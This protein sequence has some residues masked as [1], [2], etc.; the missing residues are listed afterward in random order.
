MTS[1]LLRSKGIVAGKQTVT[2]FRFYIV[3]MPHGI[4]STDVVN[5][6]DGTACQD[7]VL[8]LED[9]MESLEGARARVLLLDFIR[10]GSKQ[11]VGFTISG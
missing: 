4:C 2:S 7:V 9:R 11:T 1:S 5:V 3:G 10:K 8:M 6:A